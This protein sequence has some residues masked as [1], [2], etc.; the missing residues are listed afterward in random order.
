[1]LVFA[2][3]LETLA[4]FPFTIFLDT[5]RVDVH[6]G[7]ML[8]PVVPAAL[9][10]AAVGPLELPVAALFVIYV[11]SHIH[12]AVSPSEAA[13]AVHFIVFPLALIFSFVRP[14]VDAAAVDVIVGELSNE[15]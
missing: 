8:F 12:S 7:A 9:V 4:V 3:S 2:N 6:A 15:H 5:L 11:L 14:N 10:A 13:F 1:M